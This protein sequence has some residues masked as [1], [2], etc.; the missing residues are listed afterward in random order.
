MW[1]TIKANLTWSAAAKFYIW[2]AGMAA[3]YTASR[4]DLPEWVPPAV[5]LLTLAAG[6]LKKQQPVTNDAA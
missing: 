4:T 1:A 2:A 6:W 3:T 5:A